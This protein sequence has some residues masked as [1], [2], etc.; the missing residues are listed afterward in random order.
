[1]R[2]HDNEVCFHRRCRAQ[3]AVEGVAGN[4]HWTAS[5]SRKFSHCAD[6]LAESPFG[7][8]RLD[9]DQTLRLIIVHDMDENELRSSALRQQAGSPYGAL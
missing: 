9:L 3:D 1:M 5:L 2:A 8:A 6:L 4:D 7:L